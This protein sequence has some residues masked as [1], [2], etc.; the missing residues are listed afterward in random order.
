MLTI[1]SIRSSYSN[2]YIMTFLSLALLRIDHIINVISQKVAELVSIIIIKIH[3]P[4]IIECT[5]LDFRF[6][7][8]NEWDVLSVLD[9]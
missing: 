2:D 1:S 9:Y 5:K 3:K 4:H 7:F 6:E 8:E